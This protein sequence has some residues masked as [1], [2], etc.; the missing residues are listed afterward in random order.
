MREPRGDRGRD[1]RVRIKSVDG[2]GGFAR[3]RGGRG[4]DCRVCVANQAPR[5]FCRC[6]S[7]GRMRRC[8]ACAVQNR[9]SHPPRCCKWSESAGLRRNYGRNVRVCAS[10]GEAV[11][12][13][14][15]FAPQIQLPTRYM[16]TFSQVAHV[17]SS[18]TR[19]KTENLILR[20]VA[21]GRN[22]RV[23][24][25]SPVEIFGCARTASRLRTGSAGLHPSA[26]VPGRDWR[27]CINCAGEADGYMP[28]TEKPRAKP[29]KPRR[30]EWDG[31][32]PSAAPTWV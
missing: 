24:T 20:R 15:G 32:R 23:C 3:T 26:K 17:A 31:A 29:A 10:R 19:C 14:D 12:G 25:D 1:W 28:S 16:A 13:I 8:E 11:D 27:I 18:L 4:R 5:T 9:K 21:N 2:I 30:F 6:V 22:R 7:P